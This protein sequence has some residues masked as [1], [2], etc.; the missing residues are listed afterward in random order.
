MR[1]SENYNRAKQI[2]GKNIAQ[3]AV[4]EGISNQY[5]YAACKFHIR[6]NI[7][8]QN[9]K[10][11][12]TQW[13]KYVKDKANVNILD[14]NDFK[15]IIEKY[16]QKELAFGEIYNDG[17]VSV[18]RIT[19]YEEMK[20]LPFANFWCIR[21]LKKWNEY[22]EEPSAYFLL[23][24]NK[25]FSEESNC[26]YVMIEMY[27]DGNIGYW[28]TDNELIDER[29][30]TGRLPKLSDYKKTLGGALT[31]IKQEQHKLMSLTEINTKSQ[32]KMKQKIRLTEG[33]LHRII[34]NCIHEALEYAYDEYLSNNSNADYTG[35]DDTDIAAISRKFVPNEPIDNYRRSARFYKNSD[36]QSNG[37]VD[38]G[39][40][41]YLKPMMVGG[42]MALGGM[43][44]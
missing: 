7:P 24:T 32:Y 4:A 14:Y 21:K 34:R 22:K 25:H 3:Q 42:I 19:S 13:N 10:Y 35:L 39:I 9:L 28:S 8:F 29:G 26:M 17:V 15:K 11:W 2:Y 1:I 31:V 36:L 27:S 23:V 40:G 5:I 30:S 41:K 18:K 16:K 44:A 43:N 12:F 38:E 33:D 20:K 37:I 6:F